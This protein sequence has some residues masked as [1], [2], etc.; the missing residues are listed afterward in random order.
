[1][2]GTREQE[3][4]QALRQLASDHQQGRLSLAAYRRLRRELLEKADTDEEL[5]P[6]QHDTVPTRVRPGMVVWLAVVLIMLLLATVGWL[7][8]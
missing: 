2:T 6:V 1:V 5:M 7:L 8:R 4:S 3:F